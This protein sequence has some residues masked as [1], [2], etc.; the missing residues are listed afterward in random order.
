[1]GQFVHVYF[2]KTTGL[3]ACADVQTA[4][5][6]KACESQIRLPRVAVFASQVGLLDKDVLPQMDVRD[7]E[8]V[9]LLLRTIA[10]QQQEQLHLQQLHDAKASK[11][12]KTLRR[13]TIN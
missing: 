13:V 9:M 4:Q 12:L 5:L 1:L 3:Q 7:T 10:E 8:F 2:T 11:V 6:F